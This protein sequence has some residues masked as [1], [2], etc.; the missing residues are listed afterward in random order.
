[1]LSITSIYRKLFCR[2]GFGVHSPFVFDLI[3][4]V[5][6]EKHVYYAF[7]DIDSIRMQLLQN[8][9]LIQYR[10]RRITVKKAVKRY[11]ISQKEGEFLFR[12]ANHYKP[13]TILSIG[14]SIGLAPLYLTR[15]DSSVHCITLECEQDFVEIANHFF[16]K[17]KNPT[18]KIKTGA[19]QALLSESIDE[20][21]QIGCVFIGKDIEVYDWDKVFDHCLP[22]VHDTT[23]FVLAGIR[24]STEKQHYWTQFRQHPS[25]TVAIDLYD[26]GLLFF[27]PKLHKIFYKTII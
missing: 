2:K 14:S 15:Y 16:S 24:S 12:L 25:V 6:E 22:F 7:N 18:L 8:E 1:M 13:R 27:Q 10:D 11:G 5:I 19:Y 21:R 4:N 26:L 23:F 17:E 9:R 3:T 20:L